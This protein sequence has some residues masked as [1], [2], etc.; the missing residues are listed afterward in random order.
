[1]IKRVL[2][3]VIALGLLAGCQ[4]TMTGIDDEPAQ[5]ALIAAPVESRPAAEP[6]PAKPVSPR[7]NYQQLLRD[8]YAALQRGD[9]VAAQQG[10]ERVLSR[11]DDPRDQVRALISLAMIRLMPSSKAYDVDAAGII[12]GEL[13]RRI[14]LHGLQ[15]EYFGELEL[16]QLIQKRERELGAARA[17]AEQLRRDLAAREELIRQLRALTVDGG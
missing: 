13:D 15:Y 11:T 2:P 1:M 6:L 4:S 5:T 14:A 10:Y 16:L 8:A 7:E 17:S 9:H 3:C 12:M